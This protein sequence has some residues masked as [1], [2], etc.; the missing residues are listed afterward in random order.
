MES[1][2]YIAD[3]PS[4]AKARISFEF[5]PPKTPEMEGVLWQAVE[6]LQAHK[7]DF[8]SV[9]YGAGGSTR[10]R[11]RQTLARILKE[12]SLKP[13][14]HLTCVNATREEIDAVARDYWQLG[15]RHIVALRG[16]V[17]G[18]QKPYVPYAGGYAYANDLVAGL[19]NVA[20]FEMSVAAYPEGHP[21]AVSS[22]A[23]LDYLKRKIDAGATRAITQ[24]FFESDM[25]FRF[26]ERARKKGIRVPIVPG[27][28]PIHSYK[29][30]ARFSAMCGASIP[31]KVR[32]ALEPHE[33]NPAA[34]RAAA[35]KIA[36]EMIR[37]LAKGGATEFHF[38]TLNRGDLTSALCK[39]MGR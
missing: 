17:P 30:I 34:M 26:L 5:F 3:L 25:Y 22:E 6:G 21:E 7:P 32:A 8:V 9:T 24:Y 36:A 33:E 14:A 13:A 15:V 4:L 35:Y 38:Y 16:D 10:E 1:L 39:A 23:D 11:T 28:V 31:E 18:G 19:K 12:T 20:D 27:I 37:D 2:P 29:Q